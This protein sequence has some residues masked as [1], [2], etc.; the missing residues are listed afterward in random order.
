MT[1]LRVQPARAPLLGNANVPGDKSIAHRALL[2]SAIAVGDS[3]L[4]ALPDGQDVGRTRDALIALGVQMERRG[5]TLRVRGVGLDGLR[6]ASTR[7]DCGNSGTSARLLLGLLAGRSFATTLFGDDSLQRRPMRRVVAPLQIMGARFASE[8]TGE[9]TLPVTVSATAKLHG[10]RFA[11]EIASAQ[12]KSAILLAAL[13][14]EGETVVTEPARSRDHTERMLARQGAALVADEALGRPR[15]T[16]TPGRALAAASM[17]VPGDLSSA[18]FLLA[19]ATLVPKSR[20]RLDDVGLNPTR[21][22]FLDALSAMGGAL[23]IAEPD[24]RGAEPIGQIVASHAALRG[25]EISGERSLRAIDE[26]PLLAALAAAASGTTT[27]TNA[28]ELRHK[29]S[30]RIATTVAFIRAMGGRA[31]ARADGLVVEGGTLLGGH[32]DAC[33]DHRI[34]MAA[35]V[36]ALV[37]ERETSID[38]A[39]GIATSFPAFAR[40]LAALG[41]E[42][43]TS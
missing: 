22:G 21:A 38:G 15:L 32:V 1:R 25:V 23:E 19:A 43:E 24:A 12:V 10:A 41:A 9:L 8:A 27:I 18:A 40:T 2:F 11:L 7:I 14:A 33:G 37:C 4:A 28:A 36:L 29:E 17:R 13:R 42:I 6:A 3:E 5:E 35:A 20:V 26:L 30:D 31:E 34:A 39:D 16:L